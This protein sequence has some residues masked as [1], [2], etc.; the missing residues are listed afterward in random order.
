MNPWL[1][2]ALLAIAAVGSLVFSTLTYSLRDLSRVRLGDYLEKRG[3]AQWLDPT[4]GHV[5]DLV[6]VTAVGRL[7]C[8]IAI[9]LASIGLGERLFP[10]RTAACYGFAAALSAAVSL[11]CSVVVPNA[12]TRHAGPVIVGMSVRP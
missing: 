4:V 8:N 12:L 1:I 11:F 5:D 9:V 6:I 2:A 7:L 10:G 3:L